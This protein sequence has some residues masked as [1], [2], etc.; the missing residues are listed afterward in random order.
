[1]HHTDISSFL[2]GTS[3]S[4]VTSVTDSL[5]LDDA[6]KAYVDTRSLKEYSILERSN[7]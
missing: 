6:D 4:N 2:A 3:Y 5:L 1:M 7:S